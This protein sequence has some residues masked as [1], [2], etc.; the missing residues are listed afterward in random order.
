MLKEKEEGRFVQLDIQML[1][2]S[3]ET[4][5]VFYRENTV[6]YFNQ[7][8]K[9]L[10][11]SIA[12]GKGLPEE[13]FAPNSFFVPEA[14]VMQKG[15]LYLLRHRQNETAAN[16]LFQMTQK[17]RSCL[18]N[19]TAAADELFL[20]LNCQE[21]PEA[22]RLTQVANHTLHRLHRLTDHSDLLRQLEAG[23]K[24]VYRETSVDLAALCHTLAEH[25]SQ[26]A[27]QTG[28]G[29]HFDCPLFSLPTLGDPALLHRM[30]LNLISNAMRAAG[31][32]GEV[33]L[34]L[35]KKG[36]RI[37]ITIWDNGTG[38]EP[39]RLQFVF[40]P[41]AR[42]H[43]LPKPEDGAAMGLRLVREITVLHQGLILAENR[44]EGGVTMT[45]S[46]PLRKPGP[47]T[48][49]LA[50]PWEDDSFQLILTELS[51]V[52]PPSFYAPEDQH[53]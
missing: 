40:R 16:D 15:T 28:I 11:P 34:R 41:Q 26:L 4:P 39:D 21:L 13:F 25:L 42:R 24:G 2:D 8:A 19:L 35:E 20:K 18:T 31:S 22:A 52:L 29:F 46:L 49:H 30:L 3:F 6:R 47:D 9:H 48:P 1:L 45:I 12:S 33:G 32:G 10:F 38:V 23:E 43:R 7:W 17:L 53:G 27:A 50:S 5:A 51:D 37:Q 36:E 44:P 14:H